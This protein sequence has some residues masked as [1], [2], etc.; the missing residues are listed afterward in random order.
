MSAT[1]A[2]HFGL[3]AMTIRRRRRDDPGLQRL[4]GGD[5]ARA[6]ADAHGLAERHQ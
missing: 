6:G 4:A 1:C 5:H 3:I 2:R